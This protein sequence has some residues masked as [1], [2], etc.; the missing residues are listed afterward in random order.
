MVVVPVIE[1]IIPLDRGIDG[2]AFD[3][4]TRQLGVAFGSRR[5]SLGA[6]ARDDHDD[7][8]P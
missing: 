5:L 8:Q 6:S 7:E 2:S 4:R 1:M 3:L